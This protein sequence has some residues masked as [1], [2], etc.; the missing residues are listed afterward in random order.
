MTAVA[1]IGIGLAVRHWT[2]PPAPRTEFAQPGAARSRNLLLVTLDTL[3]ADRLGCYGYDLAET[4]VM[5]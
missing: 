2:R 1:L 4:P 3:R 5:D